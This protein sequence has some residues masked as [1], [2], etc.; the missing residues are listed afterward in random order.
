M[1]D[2]NNGSNFVFFDATKPLS[3]DNMQDIYGSYFFTYSKIENIY[4]TF[5]SS[6]A[7]DTYDSM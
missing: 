7:I 5:H 2:H 3:T 4:T 1:K 6:E